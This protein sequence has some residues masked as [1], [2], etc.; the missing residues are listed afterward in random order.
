[1]NE[2]MIFYK[3]KLK[4]QINELL[5]NNNV[6]EAKELLT[7]YES[8]IKDDAEIYSIKAI[9]AIIE[10]DL[11]YAEKILKEGYQKYNNDID[12][13]CNLAY[14]YSLNSEYVEAYKYYEIAKN[15]CSETNDKDNIEF[16]MSV[17]KNSYYEMYNKNIEDEL[18]LTPPYNKIHKKFKKL[19]YLGWLGQGNV[20]D[21]LLF[22]IFKKIIFTIDDRKKYNFIID[23]YLP[24]NNYEVDLT[25][26]D[27]II[28]GGGSLYSLSYWEELCLKASKLKIPYITWGTGFDIRDENSTTQI[29]NSYNKN[30]KLNTNL[31]KTLKV[32]EGALLSSTRGNL[33]KHIINNNNLEVIGDPGIIFNKL[34]NPY[35]YN[36]NSPDLF[37]NDE[38]VILI[39]W[40]TSFNNIIG[41]NE[42]NVEKEL[43]K[44]IN[45][46]LEQGYKIVIYPIWVNDISK[47]ID[48]AEKFNNDNVK[49]IEK[50]YDAYGICS[51]IER[52]YM[53]INLKLHANIL[54]MSMGKPFISLSYG[55]KSYD[56][57]ESIQ[58]QELSI[59]TNKLSD[60]ELLNKVQYIEENYT[61]LIERF[62]IYV[63]KYYILQFEFAK[64]ILE[65]LDDNYI[66]SL[67]K[68]N[69]NLK[70]A[71]KNIQILFDNMFVDEQK[72][73]IGNDVYIGFGGYFVGSGG[74]KIGN[75]TII[76]HKVEILTRNHNYNSDDLQSI[77]YDRRYIIKPVVIE[78]NCWI[79]SNVC[80]LPGVT[81]GEG[82][83][84]G[85][86]SV[87]TKDIPKYS[88][89][90]G[91][92]AK[93]CKVRNVDIYTSLKKEGKIYL[94]MKNS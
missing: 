82:S 23:N 11:K 71:G 81:I 84:I 43:I 49:C 38:K 47:C 72:I 90:T 18:N 31:Q 40:G 50:V 51:L 24:I 62:N 52:A 69:I 68:S 3:S 65:I 88:V 54:S 87:V 10:E 4:K 66:T 73:E 44:S 89:A 77:P 39:N 55:M 37:S 34:N 61:N 48:L 7:Q 6:K 86:G 85:M 70:K 46:L 9:V 53:T 2:E 27:L 42:N 94:K 19:L 91:N 8:I 79:G 16:E 33:S 92:P 20:G 32:I 36:N 12:I 22:D 30:I 58:S 26:Y 41:N 74:I 45:S 83:I 59:F 56:F 28:L 63:E 1:M 15:Y 17:L 67:Y 93:V 78:D 35:K 75:G 64:R 29:I 5:E 57:C 76:A 14:I 80:I 25:Q 21:D 60:K 13:L